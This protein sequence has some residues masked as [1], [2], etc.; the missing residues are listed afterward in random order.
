M[1]ISGS[2]SNQ[3]NYKYREIHIAEK[4]LIKYKWCHILAAAGSKGLQTDWLL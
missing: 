3:K 1:S 2:K 4:R